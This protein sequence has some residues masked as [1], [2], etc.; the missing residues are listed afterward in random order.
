MV[1]IIPRNGV[2]IR[3]STRLREVKRM[4]K[5]PERSGHSGLLQLFE[6]MVCT[7]IKRDRTRAAA[8]IQ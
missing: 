4:R 6:S 1:M 2:R 5:I 8:T 7:M 3:M